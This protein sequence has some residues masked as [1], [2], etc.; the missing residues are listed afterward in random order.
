M[1]VYRAA[2]TALPRRNLHPAPVITDH[3]PAQSTVKYGFGLNF[4][5]Q[6]NP[7]AT[8][9]FGRFG[10]NEG[11]HESF[12]YTEVDQTFEMGADLAGKRWSRPNDK[13]GV[14]LHLKRDQA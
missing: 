3:P 12:A 7:D 4:E 11:Q 13:L 8:H 5:Q 2:N 6:L 14:A 10:W 1:G 9:L